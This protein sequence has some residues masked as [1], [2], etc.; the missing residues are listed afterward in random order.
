MA[1]QQ[2]AP[3]R[4][5]GRRLRALTDAFHR[6]VKYALRPLDYEAFAEHFPG[7]REA[8]VAEL[9]EGYKQVGAAAAAAGCR[10]LLAASCRR[11]QVVRSHTLHPSPPGRADAAPGARVHRDRL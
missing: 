4:R 9:Y 8:L 5:A 2:Q 11:S 6:T 1:S 3:A 10:R 7:A